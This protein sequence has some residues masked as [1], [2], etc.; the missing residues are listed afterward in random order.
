[1]SP[2]QPE[3]NSFSRDHHIERMLAQI[4]AHGL[5]FVGFIDVD[6]VEWGS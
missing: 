2:L 3:I 6:D 4:A 5:R 1:M